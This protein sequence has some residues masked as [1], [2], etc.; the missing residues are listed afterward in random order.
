MTAEIGTGGID[1]D[2]AMQKFPDFLDQ[3][4]EV[5]AQRLLGCL[6]I[7][8]IDDSFAIP[9]PAVG[10][11]SQPAK[12][13]GSGDSGASQTAD[14]TSRLVVRIVETEAYDQLDPAS[15]SFH[16]M[17]H[18]TRVMFGPAGHAYVYFTYGMYYC[19]NVTAGAPGFGAAV[20]IRAVEPVEGAAVIESRSR[21]AKH[22][23]VNSLNGPAKLCRSLGVDMALYGHDLRLPPLQLAEGGLIGG[24]QIVSTPRIGITKAAERQ[25]RYVIDG[26]P[27]CSRVVNKVV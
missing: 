13:A 4:V 16:G 23:L 10:S 17:S 6:L 22:P 21:V 9:R 7:R 5:V 2:A 3:D 18:R 12:V 27:Y 8:N 20:L 14:A 19:L 25:R 11:A 1:V 15:H 26:N 24:E